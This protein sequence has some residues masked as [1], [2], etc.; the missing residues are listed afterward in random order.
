VWS[1]TTAVKVAANSTRTLTVTSENLF[2][3]A[4]TGFSVL[5][6]GSGAVTTSR[7]RA[8]T[9]AAGTVEHPGVTVTTAQTT[10]TTAVLTMVNTTNQ[11][12]W[13][14]SPANYVDIPVGTPLL[15]LAALVVTQGDS[16]TREFV[17]PPDPTTTRFGDQATEIS[18]DLWIQDDDTALQFATD[19]VVDQCVPRPNLTGL[20]IVPDP[21]IQLTDVV[22]ILDPDRTGV[23]EYVRVFGWSIV[24]EA[25]SDP[26]S[27]MT[28]DMTIDGRTLAA[29]GGWIMGVAGRS[30]IG[31]TA[32]VYNGA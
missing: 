29:P 20:A 30:E 21:R 2:A 32:Y 18:G 19:I 31:S 12:A 16:A 22:H 13:F 7:Y 3:K 4:D 1:A 14:V 5:P 23:D 24:W 10:S 25:A 17:Y 8:S 11:D 26:Q 6:N 15:R 28:Y 9:S 27:A